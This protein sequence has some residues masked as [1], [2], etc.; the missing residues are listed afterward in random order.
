VKFLLL[1]HSYVKL[2]VPP[3]GGLQERYKFPNRVRGGAPT[4]RRVPLF[5]TLGISSPGTVNA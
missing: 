3:A 1:V 2:A 4:D 5:S